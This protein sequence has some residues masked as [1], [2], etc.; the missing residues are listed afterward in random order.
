MPGTAALL[1]RH[2]V[3]VYVAALA[4]G[5]TLGLAAPS[6]AGAAGI[7]VTPVLALTLFATFLGVPLGRLGHAARDRRFLGA[8][9]A[10]NFGVAPVV[11]FGLSRLVASNHAVLVG[12]LVVLLTPCIDYVIVFTGLAGG[13]RERLLAATPL[14]LV[15]QMALLPAYLGLMAGPEVA[16]AVEPEPFIEAL[17]WL[18]AV[19]LAAAA[20][21]QRASRSGRARVAHQGRAAARWSA[22]AMVPLM[23]LTLGLVVASQVA[24][25][26][27]DLAALVPAAMVFVAFAGAMVAIGAA[28]GR[29]AG[30]DV[31]G[32]RALT[33][34]GVT[35][36]SL[37]VLPLALAL[38]PGF[39]LTP[40]VVVT[41][42]LVEL[43]VLVALVRLVPR[44]IST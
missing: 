37:V 17:V 2:Q 40:V 35:R 28:A 27:R 36:N 4:A 29:V 13:A 23:A 43:A 8:V 11:A 3:A 16:T 39:E 19:P 14:L 42:T 5:A 9:L 30:L 1:E 44:I 22:D 33:F 26:A 38:G 15:I 34:S 12:V 41:Q 10:V 20:V 24:G 6:S 21:V 7:L 25:V 32:R 18:I 31:A